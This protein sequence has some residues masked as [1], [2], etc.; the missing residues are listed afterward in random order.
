MYV[1]MAIFFIALGLGLFGTVVG[2]PPG[3]V[4]LIL[5]IVML[6]LLTKSK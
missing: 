6:Y 1:I 4:C 5:G 2:A 3:F